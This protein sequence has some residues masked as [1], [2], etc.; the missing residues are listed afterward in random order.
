MILAY[1][2]ILMVKAPCLT[3]ESPVNHHIWYLNPIFSCLESIASQCL[4]V[5]S[6]CSS[7]NPIKS[8]CGCLR[9]PAPPKGWLKHVL[10]PPKNHGASPHINCGEGFLNLPQYQSHPSPHEKSLNQLNP[11][12]S[13]E[14]LWGFLKMGLPKTGRFMLGKIPNK[15][16]WWLGV[17][18]PPFMETPKKVEKLGNMNYWSPFITINP[19]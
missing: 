15:N 5:K 14:I 3:I 10:K 11:M 19:Y 4:M 13:Y 7:L 1:I 16:G 17:P 6:S 2:L 18:V 8:H 12:K 9:N